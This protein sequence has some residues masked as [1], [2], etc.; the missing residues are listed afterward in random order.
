LKCTRY[1]LPTN[2]PRPSTVDWRPLELPAIKFIN[3]RGPKRQVASSKLQVACW[4]SFEQADKLSSNGN[5]Y[6]IYQ[7][8]LKVYIGGQ[9]V[10]DNW[11]VG[12]FIR[13]YI[14]MLLLK[15]RDCN[16]LI[17]FVNSF[18][19]AFRQFGKFKLKY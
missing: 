1:W 12:G 10:L 2:D 15:C 4:K 6:F 16:S 18:E 8:C 17:S 11:I 14:K 19:R 5:Y 3:L 7:F 13:S 9:E